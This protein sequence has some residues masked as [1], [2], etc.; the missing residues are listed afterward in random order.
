M[1]FRR[2]VLVVLLITLF[3]ATSGTAL[4]QAGGSGS[5]QEFLG[6]YGE[7][8]KERYHTEFPGTQTNSNELQ[9]TDGTGLDER[10]APRGRKWSEESGSNSS[11]FAEP[12]PAAVKRA[13]AYQDSISGFGDTVKDPTHADMFRDLWMSPG[14]YQAAAGML[15]DPGILSGAGLYMGL[16]GQWVNNRYASQEQL[17]RQAENEEEGG[18][19]IKRAFFQCMAKEEIEPTN[20]NRQPWVGAQARCLG[21]YYDPQDQSQQSNQTQGL[22]PRQAERKTLNL[23]DD[24]LAQANDPRTVQRCSQAIGGSGVNQI[25]LLSSWI[26]GEG[27]CQS[28]AASDGPLRHKC[29][30]IDH[31][32]DGCLYKKPYSQGACDSQD[33]GQ[34]TT[35]SEM[36]CLRRLPPDNESG[37]GHG[38]DKE[39]PRLVK[40]IFETLMGIYLKHC[41][42]DMESDPGTKFLEKKSKDLFSDFDAAGGFW[43]T[44]G[45]AAN[46]SSGGGSSNQVTQEELMNLYVA[47]FKPKAIVLDPPYQWAMQRKA[48]QAPGGR[49][50]CEDTFGG[51]NAQ[52]DTYLDNPAEVRNEHRVIFF[53]AKKLA[54]GKMLEG[55]I[56]MEGVLASLAAQRVPDEIRREAFNLLYSVAGTGNLAKAREKNFDELA[57][58]LKDVSDYMAAMSGK[59]GHSAT[60]SFAVKKNSDSAS[61]GQGL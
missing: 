48:V 31:V 43:S 41:K 9:F 59:R 19:A 52:I 5:S 38:P 16:S 37:E 15:V 40:N 2:M 50:N 36:V 10:W 34:T 29:D 13:L 55:Y 4:A 18:R 24:S 8:T 20:G 44:A 12:T 35:L 17:L 32:G 25:I 27:D 33:N 30:F 3:G 57:T 7:K 6:I 23:L 46:G 22:I 1:A 56:G 26:F 54:I 42:Y 53:L 51:R 11:W 45:A 39:Y 47:G 28:A 21:D 60:A 49:V 61:T 14:V 58:V